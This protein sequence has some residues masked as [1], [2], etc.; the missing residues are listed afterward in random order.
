MKT[1]TAL[2]LSFFIF[3]SLQ[4]QGSYTVKGQFIDTDKDPIVYATLSVAKD[5]LAKNVVRRLASDDKGRFSAKIT[6]PGKYYLTGSAFSKQDYKMEFEIKEGDKVVDLGQLVMQ[7]ASQEL[8]EVTITTA[9]P[10]VKVE[11][12]KLVYDMESDPEAQTSNALDVLRKVPLITVDGEDKIQVKGSSSYKILVNG[13]P[14]NLFNTSPEKVLKGMPANSIKNVEVITE[15]GAKYD[16]EGVSA[17]INLITEQKSL[18]GYTGSVGAGIDSQGA[19]NG[20]LYLAFTKGKLGFT[21]NMSYYQWKS[22]KSSFSNMT[23]FLQTG[24]TQRSTGNSKFDGDGMY[25]TALLSY[26]FDSLRLLSFSAQRYGGGGDNKS[27][28][29]TGLFKN[30]N[31]LIYSFDRNTKTE[32]EYG[33]TSLSLDYQRSFAKKGELLTLSYKLGLTPDDSKSNSQILNIWGTPP[34]T[35]PFKTKNDADGAEHTAQIDYVNPLTENHSVEAGV[36][37]IYRDNNSDGYY[38]V[39]RNDEWIDSTQ[40]HAD[41]QMSHIQSI[42]SG[43]GSYQFKKTK[44]AIKVGAR[45]EGTHQDLQFGQEPKVKTDYFNVVPSALLSYQMGMKSL[46]AGYNMQVRRPGIWYLNPYRNETDP[47]NVHYGNPNLDTEKTHSLSLTYSSFTQKLMSNIGLSYSWTNNSIED[48]SLAVIKDDGTT[49]ME[50]TYKNI[51]KNKRLSLYTYLN[52]NP[53]PIVR[54]YTNLSISYNDYKSANGDLS[55]NGFQSNAYL[56]GSLT[57]PKDFRFSANAGLYQW[58]IGLQSSK[59]TTGYYTSFSLSKELFDKKLTLSAYARDPFWNSQSSK[60][61]SSDTN[62]RTEGRYDR[63]S[64]S[65]GF[66]ISYRFGEMKKSVKTIERGISNDDVT[67][68]GSKGGGQGGGGN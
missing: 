28:G 61:S 9:K 45:F 14:S 68:G 57:L 35:E 6:E 65:F 29:Y 48:Y 55:N 18:D 66:S 49:I 10:L 1:L 58:G 23:D 40:F 5:S 43:Y 22:P 41:N 2:L 36:K 53:V 33:G 63:K 52:W 12:D 60:Y 39:F 16:S 24:Q 26:E 31:D 37:F 54:M 42:Y 13:K 30:E 51:G 19:Y 17:L 27:F 25:G 20:S 56:G 62:F 38:S 50:S 15:P 3:S 46:K 8:G 11:I 21:T 34:A 4:A 32:S 64:R 47:L 67:G 7:I 59:T 44:Y